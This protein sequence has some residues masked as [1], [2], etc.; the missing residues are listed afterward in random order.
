M[1]KKK[2]KMLLPT[3]RLEMLEDL[4][5]ETMQDIQR[6]F[7]QKSGV[8]INKYGIKT[9]ERVLQGDSG[10]DGKCPSSKLQIDVLNRLIEPFLPPKKSQ[11]ELTPGQKLIDINL[12]TQQKRELILQKLQEIAEEKG[13]DV[14]DVI[15]AE[16][17]DV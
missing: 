6:D 14:T 8:L 4:Q 7:L 3:E 1:T 12:A 17:T 2:E 9:Y 10:P 15:D 16:F 11:V 13:I 5:M